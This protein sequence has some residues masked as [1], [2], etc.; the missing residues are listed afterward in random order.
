MYFL[1]PYWGMFLQIFDIQPI[2]N[3][4]TTA[5]WFRLVLSDGVNLQQAM[6]ATQLNE[7]VKKD[8]AVK[9]SVV[10]LLKYIRNTVQNRK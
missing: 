1:G 8:L 3:A 10:Q 4:Q 7:K 5:E 9:G 6:L 2:G